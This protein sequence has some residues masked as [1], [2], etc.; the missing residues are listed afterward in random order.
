[1]KISDKR[2]Y[3]LVSV[4]W[5]RD[6]LVFWGRLSKDEEQRSYGGYTDDFS[7]CERYTLEELKTEANSD[8]H[9]YYSEPLSVLRKMDREG[10]WIVHVDDL[11]NIGKVTTRYEIFN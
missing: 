1:M 11:H 2:L 10:T 5:T 6:S 7:S 4:K 8:L 9:D 3:V